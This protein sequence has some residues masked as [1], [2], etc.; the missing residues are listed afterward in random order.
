MNNFFFENSKKID[1]QPL[2]QSIV[3]CQCN[4]QFYRTLQTLSYCPPTHL[5]SSELL[6][7]G[8][9]SE[10]AGLVGAVAL[11]LSGLGRGVGVLEVAGGVQGGQT[12]EAVAGGGLQ[13]VL[14]G[15][16]S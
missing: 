10:A 12:G 1:K 4:T 2:I 7:R 3:K 13:T 11:L 16:V 5:A 15:I 9:V 14:W 8:A 6:R